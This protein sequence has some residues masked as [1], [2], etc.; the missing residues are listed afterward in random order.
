MEPAKR[1]IL[2]CR[3]IFFYYKFKDEPTYYNDYT[4]SM[5]N[6]R[7]EWFVGIQLN[8]ESWG[9]EDTRYDGHTATVWNF[10]GLRFIK[11][12]S[13]EWEDLGKPNGQTN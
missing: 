7:H 10:L 9:K 12:Y 11:G 6:Y 1:I 5:N 8:G 4:K 2:H 13:Y 3:G